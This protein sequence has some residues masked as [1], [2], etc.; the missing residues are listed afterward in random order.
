MPS[1]TRFLPLVDRVLELLER[2]Q[3][4]GGLRHGDRVRLVQEFEQRRHDPRRPGGRQAGRVGRQARHTLRG[5]RHVTKE[6]VA[7]RRTVAVV[8]QL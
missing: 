7:Q 5:L 8:M 4:I 6:F 2:A 1:L 3:A